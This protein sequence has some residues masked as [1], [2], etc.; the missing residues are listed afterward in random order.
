MKY[1]TEEDLKAVVEE[2]SSGIY[3]YQ[4]EKEKELKERQ[5]LYEEDGSMVVHVLSPIAQVQP[6]EE[7]IIGR[8]WRPKLTDKDGNPILSKFNGQPLKAWEKYEVKALIKGKELVY[9]LGGK[10]TVLFRAFC[11]EM[12]KNDIKSNDLTGTKWKIKCIDMKKYTWSVDFLGKF[13]LPKSNGNG[14]VKDTNLQ[15]VKEALDGIKKDNFA[16]ILAG[17]GKE[18]LIGAIGFKTQ[19]KEKEV[20]VVWKQLVDEGILKEDSGKVFFN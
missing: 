11:T 14:K 12:L 18:D 7:D 6:G 4:K 10:N 2:A 19:L 5:Y 9:G 8:K 3:V 13:D 1:L 20:L 17:I 16:R 15:K